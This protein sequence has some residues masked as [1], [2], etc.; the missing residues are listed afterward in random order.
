MGEFL[1]VK[2]K[3]SEAPVLDLV[4]K[5]YFKIVSLIKVTYD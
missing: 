1:T 2:I 3:T 4:A 5:K